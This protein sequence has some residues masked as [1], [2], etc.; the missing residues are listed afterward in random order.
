MFDKV[1]VGVDERDRGRDAIALAR[2]LIAHR[3]ELTLAHV[4]LNAPYAY[5]GV[6]VAHHA[7]ERARAATLLEAV[8]A[9][10]GVDAAIRWRVAASIGRG[11][12][13]LAEIVGAD[14][15]VVGST[16][17]GL[18]G[19][20]FVGDDTRAALNGAP[21]SIAVA[22]AGYADRPPALRQIGV[23]F[24][25]SPESEQALEVAR[26][27]AER[28]H[29]SLSAFEAL[30]LRSTLGGP[31]P[32]RE[33]IEG[34]VDKVRSR[35]AARG[36]ITAHAAFGRA[37]DELAKYSESL[38]L[39]VVGSRGY[40]PVGR[41]IH[42]STSQQLARSAQCPLLVLKRIFGGVEAEPAE[43]TEQA[44]FGAVSPA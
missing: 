40:G 44:D 9:E 33:V 30:S 2:K 12:H 29:S 34:E 27:L 22:P 11:L 36:G 38:D 39:L 43:T 4:F 25:G 35:I 42:G 24:D 32:V 3:G 6:S 18:V 28:Y 37:A 41:L 17:R 7:S 20:V 26:E 14:L 21:C 19:R 1:V 13:E 31:A 5:R 8:A 16:R 23:G 15:L 10:A